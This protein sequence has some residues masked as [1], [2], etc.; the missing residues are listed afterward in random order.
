MIN[1]EQITE[2]LK[3]NQELLKKTYESAEKT[4]KYILYSA[5]FTIL[6]FVLPI[7]GLIIIIPMFL[8]SYI[9]SL[10]GLI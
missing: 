9:G 8:N 7:I 1:E 10:D 4:R 6:M 3:Q 2:I 5:I